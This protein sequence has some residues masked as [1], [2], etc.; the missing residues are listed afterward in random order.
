MR[1]H[2]GEVGIGRLVRAN[3]LGSVDRVEFD[4]KLLV[5]VVKAAVVDVGE[6]DQLVVLLEVLERTGTVD[7]GRPVANRAAIFLALGQ[8][9]RNAPLFGEALVDDGQEVPIGLARR[10]ALLLDSWRAWA[11][12]I[13]SRERAGE[14]RSVSGRRPSIIPDSQSISVP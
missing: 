10:L 6:D 3:I 5:A 11:W 14:R 8:R 7:E 4:L 12:R 9:N 1:G 13:A 2:V